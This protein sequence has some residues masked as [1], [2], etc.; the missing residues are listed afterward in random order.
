ME[1]HFGQKLSLFSWR[2]VE[3]L[4]RAVEILLRAAETFVMNGR[5]FH[6]ERSRF[7]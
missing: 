6:V 7:L 1:R 2:A 3:N 5:D 4:L